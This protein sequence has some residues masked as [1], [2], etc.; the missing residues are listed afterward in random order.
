MI[1]KKIIIALDCDNLKNAL[2]IIKALK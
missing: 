2:D 1:E